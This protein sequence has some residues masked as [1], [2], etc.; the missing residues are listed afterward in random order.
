[1][2]KE[3]AW[4]AV[5]E[6]VLRAVSPGELALMKPNIS[7]AVK[8][9]L[10]TNQFVPGPSGFGGAE[11]A[12]FLIPALMFLLTEFGKGTT[13]ELGKTFGGFIAKLFGDDEEHSA[14]NAEALAETRT[15]FSEA[16]R[17]RGV[18]PAKASQAADVLVSTFV[19]H[20]ELLKALRT[21]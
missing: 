1:M 16:L 21:K 7:S 9:R 8:G 18:V 19:E 5:V 10:P 17:K 15:R 4:Q 13:E 20:P 6:P 11:G 2:T 3:S 14:I 12:V